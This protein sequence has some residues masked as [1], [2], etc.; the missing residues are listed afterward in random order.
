MAKELSG[1]GR[2][3]K[4]GR[5][6]P[7]LVFGLITIY[8]FGYLLWYSNTAL[9]LHPVLDAKELLFL[10]SQFATNT[11]PAEPFYR[12]PLYP[13]VLSLFQGV[14]INETMLP[15][16]ARLVN[17]SLHI[18]NAL[19]VVSI[20]CILWNNKF[21]GLLAGLLYGLNPV[22]LH[23]ASDV[24]DIT[25]AINLMLLGIFALA[26]CED[27]QRRLPWQLLASI[28]FSFAFITRPQMLMILLLW[29]GVCIFRE[30]LRAVLVLLPVIFLVSG[31]AAT[32]YYLS[33]DVRI[34]P[35]QGAFNLWAANNQNSNGRYFAHEKDFVLYDQDSNP[36][37]VESQNLFIKNN[38]N[39]PI[40]IQNMSN[41]WRQQTISLIVDAP[42]DWMVLVASK[43]WYLLNNFEQYNNKT[44]F[45]HK[46]RSPWLQW[47]PISWA[48]IFS[49]AMLGIFC[50][51]K[52]PLTN[53]VVLMIL[54]YSAGLLLTFV[55]AR[56]RLPLVPLLCI[57]SGGVFLNLVTRK[58]GVPHA[59]VIAL[60][61]I[62]LIKLP[63]DNPNETII[64]D[65]L[66]IA[67]ANVAIGNYETT[68]QYTDKI[69]RQYPDNLRANE[70]R[71]IADYNQWLYELAQDPFELTAC[72]RAASKSRSAKHILGLGYWRLGQQDKASEIWL[73][74]LRSE[75]NSQQTLAY[76]LAGKKIEVDQVLTSIGVN[77]D[78]DSFLLAVLAWLGNKASIDIYIRENSEKDLQREFIALEHM[79]YLH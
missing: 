56:F 58:I 47:N 8:T 12:A 46:Q 55:S 42:M 75:A 59:V 30:R 7:L 36:A 31:L 23:F 79:F 14:G 35:W 20:A 63:N 52:K 27:G 69:L 78:V 61:C 33:G 2:G 51:R 38:P 70:S 4:Y 62:C 34:L 71:C 28:A 44:F 77:R 16:V 19:L 40:T 21:S 18:I 10:S 65:Q 26:R 3:V 9:G 74:L 76:L 54:A 49:T 43:A 45:F 17:G 37:R 22:A 15:F 72:E 64:Q 6:W 73:E 32:N 39:K 5:Y 13:F 57:F 67:T 48:L 60:F 29:C 24:L 1:T 66:L 68:R 25:F 53:T 11:L 50:L 41:Y